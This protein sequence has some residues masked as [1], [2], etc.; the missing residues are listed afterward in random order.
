MW[1]TWII[2][3]RKYL[4]L[5]PTLIQLPAIWNTAALGK[6][7]T[8]ILSSSTSHSAHNAN[9]R[10][11]LTASLPNQRLLSFCNVDKYR[12]LASAYYN[13]ILSQLQNENNPIAQI[14]EIN[15]YLEY[16]YI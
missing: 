2:A 12:S 15:Q 13:Y 1:N 11:G 9:F 10:F 4:C 6:S 3:T 5:P 16:I 14:S 8:C 7:M